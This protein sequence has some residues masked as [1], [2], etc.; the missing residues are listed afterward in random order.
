MGPELAVGMTLASAGLSVASGAMQGK[1]TA[2]G[3][4]Q[5][6]SQAQRTAFA[7][8]TAADQTDSQLRDE[9]SIT[10]GNIDA[11]RAAAGVGADSPTGQAI[12][13]RETT[14]SDRQRRI[15]VG[16][17]ISQADASDSDALFYR[18]AQSSA[19]GLGWLSGF[20]GAMKSLSG[21]SMPR[22]A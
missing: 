9:L 7:A 20:A 17:L 4:A 6:E 5:K 14:V 3:Y 19:L 1:A 15:K 2:A 13:E 12:R 16:N 8:R 10:L 18:S 21:L 11:I 22:G